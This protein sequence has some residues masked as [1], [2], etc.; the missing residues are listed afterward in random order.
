MVKIRSDGT[1]GGE[2]RLELIYTKDGA[3]GTGRKGNFEVRNHAW[4]A[5]EQTPGSRPFT[6]PPAQ[7]YESVN[8]CTDVRDKTMF[9]NGLPTS[10]TYLDVGAN[11]TLTSGS[12]EIVM[13]KESDLQDQTYDNTYELGYWTE[14]PPDDLVVDAEYQVELA[15]SDDIANMTFEAGLYVPA[16]FDLSFPNLSQH[17]EI[18]P[19]EDFPFIWTDDAPDEDPFLFA[20]VGFADSLGANYF[21]IGPNN[22]GMLIP[23]EVLDD[24]PATGVVQ[25]GLLSHR[26]VQLGDQE[27]RVDLLGLNCAESQY[28]ITDYN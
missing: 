16:D 24:L 1:R 21:C 27:K 15:G 20:F 4:F 23:Q 17:V 5:S 11:V 2:I 26:A 28:T 22:G 14:V 13:T 9:P 12:A 7:W 3:I 6:R 8:V 18:P 19:A 25:F 10:R